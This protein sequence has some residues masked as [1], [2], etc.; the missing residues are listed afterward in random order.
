MKKAMK[1]PNLKPCPFCGEHR[2]DEAYIS[3][4]LS[5]IKFPSPYR[6]HCSCGAEGP[7]AKDEKKAIAAW[8]KRAYARAKK[9][10]AEAEIKE[11]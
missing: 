6:I 1:M 8:N 2:I 11:S 5:L 10:M 4:L 9:L 3:I 7:W